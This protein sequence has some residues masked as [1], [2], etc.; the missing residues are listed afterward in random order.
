MAVT[1]GAAGEST[2]AAVT[3][4]GITTATVVG[5]TTAFVAGTMVVI[6]AAITAVATNATGA[7]DA[8]VTVAAIIA[9]INWINRA[10]SSDPPYSYHIA[11]LYFC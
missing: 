3:G 4:A 11:F 8:V 6:G 10:G 1:A 9:A 2:T 7:T 5:I